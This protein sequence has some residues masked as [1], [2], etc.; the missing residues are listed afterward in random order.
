MALRVSTVWP[1]QSL[2]PSPYS[3][4][5][6]ALSHSSH[7]V[8]L[9]LECSSARKRGYISRGTEWGHSGLIACRPGK[10]S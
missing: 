7:S 9:V 6:T 10:V 8:N 4:L 3:S 2:L 1:S 5:E